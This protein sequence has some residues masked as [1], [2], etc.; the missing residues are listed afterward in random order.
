[1]NELRLLCEGSTAG[2]RG[3]I[4]YIGTYFSRDTNTVRSRCTCELCTALC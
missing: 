1:M 2:V 3:V 4:Q